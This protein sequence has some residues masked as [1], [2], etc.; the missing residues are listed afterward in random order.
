MGLAKLVLEMRRFL[1]EKHRVKHTSGKI[2][3]TLLDDC[4]RPVCR[5]PGSATSS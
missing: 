3:R 2:E 1:E 5:T 4:V